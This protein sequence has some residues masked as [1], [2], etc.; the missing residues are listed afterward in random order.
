MTH[1]TYCTGVDNGKNVASSKWQVF[2][3]IA[4]KLV[5]GY[6]LGS[7]LPRYLHSAQHGQCNQMTQSKG[8]RGTTMCNQIYNKNKIKC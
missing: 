6:N 2:R 5:Q 4:G 3:L 8:F 7:S 1:Y